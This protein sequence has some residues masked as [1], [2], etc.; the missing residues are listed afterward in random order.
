MMS[1]RGMWR[2]VGVGF[3]YVLELASPYYKLNI[4][5]YYFVYATGTHPPPKFILKNLVVVKKYVVHMD[6]HKNS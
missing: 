4:H 3:S 2:L 1:V 5:K 6:K